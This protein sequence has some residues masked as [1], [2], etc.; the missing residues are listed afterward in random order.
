MST[1]LDEL[2]EL[3]PEFDELYPDENFIEGDDIVDSRE[4]L[5]GYFGELF[6]GDQ[7]GETTTTE[8]EELTPTDA[9]ESRFDEVTMNIFDDSQKLEYSLW[10]DALGD[11]QLFQDDSSDYRTI[12]HEDMSSGA[13]ILRRLEAEMLGLPLL[14]SKKAVSRA[15]RNVRHGINEQARHYTRLDDLAGNIRQH[16]LV[17]LDT[18]TTLCGL[19]VG[20]ES[21]LPEARY[22]TTGAS[23]VN[24]KPTLEGIERRQAGLITISV[25]LS[26]SASYHALKWLVKHLAPTVQKANDA[27][28]YAHNQ[29]DST[30][31]RDDVNMNL[32]EIRRQA[33]LGRISDAIETY[34]ERTCVLGFDIILGYAAEDLLKI[35]AGQT[36]VT[37]QLVY[38]FK[39][40]IYLIKQLLNGEPIG[41]VE[42]GIKPSDISG[43]EIFFRYLGYVNT[44]DSPNAMFE[45][46]RNMDTSEP[47]CRYSDKITKVIEKVGDVYRD[48]EGVIASYSHVVKLVNDLLPTL[49]EQTR[50]Q[51]AILMI[52]CQQ[53]SEEVKRCGETFAEVTRANALAV[54]ICTEVEMDVKAYVNSH[55]QQ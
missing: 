25:L 54:K 26:S 19:G 51:V 2:K 34:D 33:L 9:T 55:C 38:A 52:H 21:F 28:A 31:C 41:R 5:L 35:L 18:H 11:G 13:E 22:Y 32:P 15:L 24:L 23:T 36:E 53:F 17:S 42:D 46:V 20:M 39:E 29:L 45:S 1:V 48:I 27:V 40:R 43:K 3:L 6:G 16:Q 37:K 44:R 47:L 49:D 10:R 7:D 50:H 4:F 12:S 30:R 14:E 8:T